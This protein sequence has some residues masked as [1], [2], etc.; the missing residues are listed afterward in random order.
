MISLELLGKMIFLF[1][2][3]IILFFRRKM[4]DD[5]SQKNTRKYDIFF[6]C[7]KK[8]VFLKNSHWNITFLAVLSGKIIFLFL[9][10][11]IL[12]FR[13]KS[14]DHLSQKKKTKKHGNI[15]FPSN[16]P[17]GSSFQKKIALEYDLS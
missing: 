4:K 6:K 13:R 9:E 2:G 10:N 7:S 12:F 8:M 14:K 16:A 17:K 15:I 3:N 5:L 11:M 1:P